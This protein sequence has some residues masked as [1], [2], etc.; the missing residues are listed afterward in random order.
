ML[1]AVLDHDYFCEPA[2]TDVYLSIYQSHRLRHLELDVERALSLRKSTD[3][4]LMGF[5]HFTAI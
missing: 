5:R 1:P 3:S 2:D 4:H